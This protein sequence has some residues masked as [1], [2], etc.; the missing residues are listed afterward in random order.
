MYLDQGD[1]ILL[2]RYLVRGNRATS[3]HPS[4][5][6]WPSGARR[7]PQALHLFQIAC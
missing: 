4:P 5:T 3:S 1:G 2:Q 6:S 7:P